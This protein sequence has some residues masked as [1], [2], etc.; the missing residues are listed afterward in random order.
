MSRAEISGGAGRALVNRGIIRL[1][2][3]TEEPET[4]AT[5][6]ITGPPRSGTSLV[7]AGLKFAGVFLGE[8]QDDI[9]HEDIDIAKAIESGDKERL[10]SLIAIRNRDHAVWGFKRPNIF[11]FLRP[12]DVREF[13]NPKIIVSFRDPI[14]V[15][16]RIMRSEQMTF[17]N[18]LKHAVAN[19]NAALDFVG[20][21]EAPKFLFSY[22]K[23]IQSPA[24]FFEALFE[25]CGLSTAGDQ[26]AQITDRVIGLQSKYLQHARAE[27]QGVIDGLRGGSIVGWCARKDFGDASKA[28]DI[29]DWSEE[30][31]DVELLVDGVHAKYGRASLYRQDLEAAGIGTG[32]HGFKISL[33]N[34]ALTDDSRIE[35]LVKGRTVHLH[36][37]GGVVRELRGSEVIRS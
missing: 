21:A 8:R 11:R 6:V 33:E 29:V 9:V 1:S 19:T 17:Q 20:K 35:V 2:T 34:V 16:E 28:G 5:I 25:F 36:R 3:E 30:D 32:K 13:R 26:I 7:A 10:Q 15:S 27:F 23:V 4:E 12:E 31:L 14:A 22:D 37:S 24:E 18:A